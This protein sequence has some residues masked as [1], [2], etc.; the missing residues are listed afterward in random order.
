MVAYARMGRPEEARRVY[1]LGRDALGP[2]GGASFLYEQA[3]V[4]GIVGG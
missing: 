3:L 2:E 4:F 1:S